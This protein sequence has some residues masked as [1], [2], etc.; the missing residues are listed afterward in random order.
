MTVE[1]E[2]SDRHVMEVTNGLAAEFSG[3]LARPVVS[4]TVLDAR[5]DLE[6]QIVPEALSEMLHQLAR[7]RL[8]NL[9]GARKTSVG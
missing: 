6:G 5:R 4:K 9:C 2:R 8:G 1:V 3:V 7:H